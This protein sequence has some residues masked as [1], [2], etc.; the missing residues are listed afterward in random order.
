MLS[1]IDFLPMLNA[2]LMTLMITMFEARP[3]MKSARYHYYEISYFTMPDR[4]IG[5]E[6]LI[7]YSARFPSSIIS[8]A[9]R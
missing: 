6:L 2:G 1:P 9:Q 3:F 5:R 4:H 8:A 7:V